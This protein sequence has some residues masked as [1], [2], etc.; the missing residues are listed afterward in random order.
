MTVHEINISELIGGNEF[1]SSG[2]GQLL[3]ERICYMLSRDDIVHVDFLGINKISDEALSE[4]IGKLYRSD[5][6]DKLILCNIKYINVTDSER[7][8]INR[9]VN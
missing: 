5:E 9:F 1:I 2:D 3:Y 7:A 4:S 8:Q 6:W